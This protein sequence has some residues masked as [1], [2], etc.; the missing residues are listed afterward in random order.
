MA[1]NEMKMKQ[2]G[3]TLLEVLVVLVVMGIISALAGPNVLHAYARVQLETVTQQIASELRLARQL[4]RTHRVQVAVT[5]DASRETIETRYQNGTTAHHHYQYGN[6]GV[7]VDEPSAG[8]EILF[9]PNGKYATA[10]T[11]WLR[12]K[13]GDVQ[14]MTVGITGRVR[15]K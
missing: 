14:R 12:N 1:T 2:D 3:H 10:T 13:Q 8:P 9:H 7:M 11:I 6:T 15:V 4:A 5:F